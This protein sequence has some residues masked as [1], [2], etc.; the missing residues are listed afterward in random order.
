MNEQVS[1]PIPGRIGDTDAEA[2][3]WDWFDQEV[4]KITKKREAED[5]LSEEDMARMYAKVFGGRYGKIVLNDLMRFVHGTASFDPALGFY[6]AA[7]Y[8]FYREGI[9]QTPLY[10]LRMVERGKGDK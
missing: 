1:Q 3:G 2:K 9:K 6:N 7:A 5:G 8:G 10:V 4:D